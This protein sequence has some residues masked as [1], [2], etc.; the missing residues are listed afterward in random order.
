MRRR[1]AIDS[2]DGWDLPFTGLPRFPDLL[3]REDLTSTVFGL[4]S[5]EEVKLERISGGMLKLN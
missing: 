2:G 4:G 3:F 1:A 5:L